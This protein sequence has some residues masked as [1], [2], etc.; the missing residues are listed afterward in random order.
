MSDVRT[1]LV[2]TKPLPTAHSSVF[3]LLILLLTGCAA[4][5]PKLTDMDLVKWSGDRNGCQGYR[6]NTISALEQQKSKLL[7]LSA[8][9]LTK[10]L[11]KPDQIE[12]YKRNQKLFYYHLN[13]AASCNIKN[14]SNE[15][16][17]L[18]IRLNAMERAK[19]I[20]ITP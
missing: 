2:F 6:Q 18:M 4:D 1:Q 20:L 16:L 17:R 11:G 15:S 3:V 19:E 12:L 9:D 5:L 13:P 14:Q 7:A 10:L 8:N